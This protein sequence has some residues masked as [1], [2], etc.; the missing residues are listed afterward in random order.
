MTQKSI[1]P[2]EVSLQQE[3]SHGG[4]I[5]A[6]YIIGVE[7]AERF[8]YYGMFGNLMT[9]LTDVLGESTATAAKN[10]N[11]WFGITTLLPLLGAV[12][13][14]SYLGRF[15]AIFFSSLIY[16]MGLVMLT[17]STTKAI[18]PE[19]RGQLFFF[20]LYIVSIGEA[21]HKPCVQAFGAD[22]FNEEKPEERKAKSSFFNWWYFGTSGGAMTAML[23]VI[24]VQDNVGWAVGFGIPAAAM[25]MALVLFLLGR[26][27]YRLQ[28]AKGSS[29]LTRVAQVLVAAGRKWRLSVSKDDHGGNI[30][31]GKAGLNMGVHFLST[32]RPLAPTH[33]FRFLDKATVVDNIDLSSNN[34]NNWRLCTVTQVEEVKL[35]LRLVPIWFSGLMY[36]VVFAQTNTLFTKQGRTMDRRIGSKFQIPPA[37]LQ[38]SIPLVVIFAVPIYDRI[39]VPVTRRLTGIPY[40]VTMLQRIG[41]GL[42]ISTIG[43]VI[44]ALVESRRIL[45]S[46]EHGLLEQPKITVPMSVWWLLPQYMI[47][48]ISDVFA[49]IGLTELFYDQMP[50]DMRSIGSAVFLSMFGTGSLLSSSVISIVQSMSSRFGDK[51]LDNNLN[52]A[53]L[54]YYYWLLAGLS[55]LWLVMYVGL[56]KFFVYKKN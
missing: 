3:P 20:S 55:S 9:Y 41:I 37:S 21:G 23:I 40:G 14:D 44:A 45:I 27:R 28:A 31:E 53:H 50:E 25:A 13:A 39:F 32:T 51:W 18:P 48:G 12:I 26:R 22:Q 29:P 16:L 5:S 46:K 7:I 19:F 8:A 11:I 15:K 49:V 4:W 17:V 54:D 30:E 24:Y 33:Q 35:L 38:V 42:F 2:M 36:A 43:M 52:K 1:E 56:A 47:W 6:I 34:K 10:V